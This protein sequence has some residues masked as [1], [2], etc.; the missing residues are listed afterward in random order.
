M[1]IRP[2]DDEKKLQD[3]SK[4]KDC[5]MRPRFLELIKELRVK[6]LHDIKKKTFKGKPCS[7]TMFVELCQFFCESINKGGLPQIESNWE[8][9]CRAESVRV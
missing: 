4:V 1:L 3:M 2:V 6:V 8:L 5:D 7:P 9:V